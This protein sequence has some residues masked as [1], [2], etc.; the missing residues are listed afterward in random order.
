MSG[1]VLADEKF[2]VGRTLPS[3]PLDESSGHT[4]MNP[5]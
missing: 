3:K 2:S 1:F 5:R 4:S